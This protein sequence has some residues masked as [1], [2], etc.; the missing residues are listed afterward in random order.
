M[1]SIA[2]LGGGFNPPHLGHL[3]LSQQVLFFT[4][5][6][7]VWWM[8]YYAHPWEKPSIDPKHRL[9]MGK[10]MESEGIIVSDFEILAKK[11]NFTFETIEKL[12]KAYPQHQFSWIIGSDLVAEFTTW[13]G[14]E[15]IVAHV[16]LLVFPRAGFPVEKL[17]D[18]AFLINDKLLT[19]SD[20]SSEKI[21][22]MV[23]KGLSIRG[24]VV[25]SVEEY[26]QRH[27]LYI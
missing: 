23:K 6:T 26:I 7:Q 20:I 16:K 5:N 24:L 19:T 14:W 13:E 3:L 8:P 11:K 25:P 22:A 9:A 27:Q 2:V 4:E 21:R 10:L 15:K 12:I 1:A 18:N 17:P